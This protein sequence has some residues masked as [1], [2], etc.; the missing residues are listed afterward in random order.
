MVVVVVSQ[1][2]QSLSL[3]DRVLFDRGVHRMY[4]PIPVDRVPTSLSL[5]WMQE[6]LGSLLDWIRDA[7]LVSQRLDTVDLL[8]LGSEGHRNVEQTEEWSIS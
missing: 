4:G 3:P 2:L 7:C 5:T 6:L 8:R 1:V